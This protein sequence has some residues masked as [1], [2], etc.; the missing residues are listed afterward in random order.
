MI[1]NYIF[2][3]DL[4]YNKYSNMWNYQKYIFN[5]IINLKLYNKKT[6]KSF[7]I[8]TPNYLLFA[9]HFHVYTMGRSFKKEHIISYNKNFKNIN[10][11]IYKVDRGGSVTYHGPG[12]LVVYPI[13]DLNHFFN[14]IYKY[15]RSLEE[16]V[17]K[18]LSFYGLKGNR[19]SG[20]TGVWLDINNSN[21]RKICSIGIK[22]N[23]WV[24]MHGLALNIN[25]DLKYFK[26]II[27]CGIKNKEITSISKEVGY[28][29][30]INEVKNIMLNNFCK[31]FKTKF[32]YFKKIIY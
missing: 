5:S 25:N 15:L 7:K 13:L 17:I 28:N 3:T 10:A 23:N 19:S 6:S 16:V 11:D 31:V 21:P 14:D 20:E 18:T 24:T 29:I 22:I 27:P 8:I 30:S 32:L 4:G 2:F 1:N 9:E 26:Y 12:Q